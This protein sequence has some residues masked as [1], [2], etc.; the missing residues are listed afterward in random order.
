MPE[1]LDGW[2]TDRQIIALEREGARNAEFGRLLDKAPLVQAEQDLVRIVG[3]QELP[4]LRRRGNGR[5]LA[6][7]GFDENAVELG[8]LLLA[9][10]DPQSEA[11]SEA[12]EL[13]DLDCSA[14]RARVE[15]EP[16]A[17][18]FVLG[19]G[20][21][22]ADDRK[23]QERERNGIGVGHAK[24]PAVADADPAKRIE[25]GRECELP[26]SEK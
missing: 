22:I 15:I 18:I 13:G 23:I 4:V 7:V 24:Q 6:V 2:Q 10:F 8:A 12:V 5:A 17:L 25:L 16:Q 14:E 9:A 21:E 11:F 20:L 19:V 26:E 1:L 3:R